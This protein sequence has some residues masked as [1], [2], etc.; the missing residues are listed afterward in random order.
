M[1]VYIKVEVDGKKTFR[2]APAQPD[3]NAEYWLREQAG[4]KQKWHRVGGYN[5]VK[6]AQILL[7]R[8]R[9]AKEYGLSV[10]EAKGRLTVSEAVE[11]YIQRKITVGK[12]PG[13]ISAYRYTLGLFST[14]SLHL[15][16]D[17]VT[18]DHCIDFVAHCRKRGD[19]Q[20][21][22]ANRFVD[23]MSLMKANGKG[24][25]VPKSDW[26]NFTERRVESYTQKELDA[27][28]R[29]ARTKKE[30][31]FLDLLLYTGFRNGEIKHLEW[32]DIDF[33]GNKIH[34]QPKP[35]WDWEVKTHECRTVRVPAKVTKALAAWKQRSKT[36]LILPS[37]T[38]KPD[39]HLIRIV[40]EL[41]ERAGI[42]GRYDCHKFRATFATRKSGEDHKPQD[43]QKMLGHKDLA[44]TMRYLAVTDLDDE[45]FVKKIEE[46]A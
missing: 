17:E 26:P 3:M 8:E 15:Y 30:R 9:V 25:M 38:N 23:V 33:V 21:T 12:R 28:Y 32:T 16:I 20:R 29:A 1:K 36:A 37:T 45:D 19:G 41:A 27:F 11:R 13:T 10:P 44:T 14:F 22:V 5:D 42:T 40:E 34:V 24:G 35:H 4:G 18:A 2:K 7:E 46:A 6:K 31:L 39:D 43:I